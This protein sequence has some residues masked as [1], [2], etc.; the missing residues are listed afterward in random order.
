MI[1]T[2]SPMLSALMRSSP[3]GNLL[4]NHLAAAQS[5]TIRAKVGYENVRTRNKSYK[6]MAKERRKLVRKT[7]LDGDDKEDSGA[8]VPPFFMPQ[9]YKLLY[10]VMIDHKNCGRLGRKPMPLELKQKL[11]VTMKEYNEFKTAEK[12]LM[13]KER[14]KMLHA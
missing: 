7:K 4:L 1:T 6:S 11:A 5:L 9:R 8:E 2:T 10:S 3:N 14:A 12:T 13:D